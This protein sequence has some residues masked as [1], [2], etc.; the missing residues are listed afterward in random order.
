MGN[1]RKDYIVILGQKGSARLEKREK[2]LKEQG[3]E[4]NRLNDGSNGEKIIAK[5]RE[6]S[7]EE[8]RE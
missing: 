1:I 5:R 3:Y 2:E 8:E 7:R 6:N 4:V